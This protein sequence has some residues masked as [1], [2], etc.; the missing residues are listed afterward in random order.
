MKNKVRIKNAS[1]SYE[2]ETEGSAEEL[3]AV[4]GEA[5]G[6]STLAPTSRFV[7]QP[8]PQSFASPDQ[9]VLPEAPQP[10]QVARAPISTPATVVQEDFD[11]DPLA[12]RFREL[13]EEVNR[14]V[15]PQ[16]VY[17]PPIYHHVPVPPPT[18]MQQ[19]Q[20]RPT[21]FGEGVPA[22]DLLRQWSDRMLM[23]L[24]TPAFWVVDVPLCIVVLSVVP[25]TQPVVKAVPFVGQPVVN[26][27]Q[28]AVKAVMQSKE[29]AKPKPETKNQPSTKQ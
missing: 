26:T 9:P 19:S 20:Q 16:P 5:Y 11:D 29:D 8:S 17:Q 28:G 23:A 3:L 6:L 10:V 13:E 24:K 1:G 21:Y 14:G 15:Y 7:P 27:V 2:I 12:A 25:M 18:V 4:F 22:I